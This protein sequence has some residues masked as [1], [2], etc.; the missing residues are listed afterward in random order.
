MRFGRGGQP[1]F[2]ASTRGA[3]QAAAA[4]VQTAHFAVALCSPGCTALCS[5]AVAQQHSLHLTCRCVVTARATHGLAAGQRG[6]QSE[7][8][9]PSSRA[10]LDAAHKFASARRLLAKVGRNLDVMPG[11]EFRVALREA[12]AIGAQVGMKRAAAEPG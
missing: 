10:L 4:V 6:V 7:C 5:A 11:E 9:L 8:N 3:Q 2:K 12:H 1:R